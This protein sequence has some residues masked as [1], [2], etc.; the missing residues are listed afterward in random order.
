MAQQRPMRFDTAAFAHELSRRRGAELLDRIPL[1]F[2][3][4]ISSTSELVLEP[5]PDPPG[6]ELGDL[7]RLPRVV[8]REP[9]RKL[10]ALARVPIAFA[11]LNAGSIAFLRQAGC[12][13]EGCGRA[14]LGIHG[15]GHSCRSR[16]T[17]TRSPGR[18]RLGGA[19]AALSG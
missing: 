3:P 17:T 18:A 11:A 13:V 16:T 15:N 7:A 10:T 9:V 19:N 2:D 1:A 4:P 14:S 6:V 5:F 12:T 8:Q